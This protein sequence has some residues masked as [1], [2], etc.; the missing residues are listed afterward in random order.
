MNPIFQRVDR[1][2]PYESVEFLNYSS[3]ID[4]IKAYTTNFLNLYKIKENEVPYK[5]WKIKQRTLKKYDETQNYGLYKF[6][7]KTILKFKGNKGSLVSVVVKGP[8]IEVHYLINTSK[9]PGTPV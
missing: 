2:G 7:G 1:L 9:L 5:I 8:G 4:E 6:Y 3:Y